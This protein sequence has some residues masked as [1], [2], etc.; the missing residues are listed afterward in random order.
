[1]YLFSF[2]CRGMNFIDLLK[3]N[4]SNLYDGRL[5]Y[6]RTKT[7]VHLD[8]K[9]QNHSLK[10][11]EVYNQK[12]MNSYLFPLL[13]TEEMTTKQIKY[14]SH[15]LLGQI[16]PALKQMMEVLK[17]SKHITF[18]TARHTF[19]TFLKFETTPIDAISEMLGHTEIRTTQAYLNKLPNKKLDKIIDDVFENS[20]IFLKQLYL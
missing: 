9:L 8:F 11:L 6:I 3:L 4:N 19:V 13:L 1:M 17:I 2:Y 16:N 10:I 18:Y 7:G 14:R 15:K 12:S 5:S 20:K